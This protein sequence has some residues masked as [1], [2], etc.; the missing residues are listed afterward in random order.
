MSLLFAALYPQLQKLEANDDSVQDELST[1]RK[2]L[3]LKD[4]KDVMRLTPQKQNNNLEDYAWVINKIGL[5]ST[6]DKVQNAGNRKIVRA[7]RYFEKRI[8]ALIEGGNKK[9]III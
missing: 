4:N 8:D 7:H 5:L 9:R 3:I 2:R 1:L 6:A